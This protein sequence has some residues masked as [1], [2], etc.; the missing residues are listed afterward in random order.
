MSRTV[1]RGAKTLPPGLRRAQRAL[2][3]RPSQVP[4]APVKASFS[5]IALTVS[6]QERSKVFYAKALEPLGFAV[7][8]E[9]EGQYVR[10]SNGESCVI[11]LSEVRPEYSGDAYHRRRIGLHHFALRVETEAAVDAMAEHLERLAIPLAGE[12]R[13]E[14]GYRGGYYCALFEDPDRIL[15]EIVFHRPEYFDL[16]NG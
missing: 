7:A 15:V 12:G 2:D 6:C 8:G 9:L 10:L 4:A 13:V 11:V 5:H 14:L 16:E 1:G 3:G